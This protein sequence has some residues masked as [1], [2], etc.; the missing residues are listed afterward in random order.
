MGYDTKFY[1]V[2]HMVPI[3]KSFKLVQEIGTL[4]QLYHISIFKLY[5][6][7]QM[8]LGLLF[9]GNISLDDRGTQFL[10]L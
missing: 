1:W 4:I 8:Y 7:I 6:L 10:F 3:E 2:E 5:F 9:S